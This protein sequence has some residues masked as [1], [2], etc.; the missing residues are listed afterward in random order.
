MAGAL[1]AMLALASVT[2]QAATAAPRT[3]LFT[4]FT[5]AQIYSVPSDGS[6][7]PLDLG[8][9]IAWGAR[10]SPDGTRLAYVK[11]DLTGFHLMTAAPD[12]TDAQ[13]VTSFDPNGGAAQ[14]PSW[15]PDGRSLYFVR[16]QPSD[17][18]VPGIYRVNVDGS[19]LQRVSPKGRFYGFAVSPSGTQL[20]MEGRLKR[21]RAVW[22]E[23]LPRFKNPLILLNQPVSGAIDWATPDQITYAYQGGIFTIHPDG[24]GDQLLFSLGPDA[25]LEDPA[26]SPDGTQIAYVTGPD[27]THTEVY[28]AAPDGSN[29]REITSVADQARLPDW[30]P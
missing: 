2:S 21:R 7:P 25:V 4:Q 19:G 11:D 23:S 14:P 20:V 27:W 22:I 3:L 26:W 15:S 9:G 13:L 18:L 8:L 12:G 29:A 17:G 16:D 30:Q 24:T 6:Q 5:E 10:Y 28:V 1:L